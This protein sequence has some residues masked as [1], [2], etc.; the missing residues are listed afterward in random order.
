MRSNKDK[1]SCILVKTAHFI[2]GWGRPFFAT[3]HVL[4][5]GIFV[6]HKTNLSLVTQTPFY[7]TETVRPKSDLGLAPLPSLLAR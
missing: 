6:A 4:K 1:W 3:I 7:L 2:T 5:S